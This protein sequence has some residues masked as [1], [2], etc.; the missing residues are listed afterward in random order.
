MNQHQTFEHLSLPFEC[1][2]AK[3]FMADKQEA[4]LHHRPDGRWE[5]EW[6]SDDLIA[7]YARRRAAYY[8]ARRG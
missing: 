6:A 8:R 5:V 3:A 7:G 1:E 2:L 4:S